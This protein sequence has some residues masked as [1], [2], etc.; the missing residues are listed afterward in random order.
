MYIY[1]QSSWPNFFWSSSKITS[2]LADVSHL[3]G[4]ML[5]LMEAMGFESR[6]EANL[7]ILTQ[8]VIKTSEIE[9]ERLDLEQ[10]RSSLAKRLGMDYERSFLPDRNVDG[11]VDV[12]FDATQHYNKKLTKERLFGWHAALFPMGRT[13]LQR[14]RVGTWRDESSG[15]MQVIS[16]PYGREKIHYEAPSYSVL[17]LEMK[18]F[19]KWFNSNS[20]ASLLLKSAVAHFW[21]VTIHPFDD[22]NGRIG[23][24]ISDMLLAQSEKSSQ[25]FYSMSS[26]ILR[27]RNDYYHV[28]ETCQK[29]T[30]DITLW[31]EWYLDCLKHAIESSDKILNKVIAKAK[32]WQKYSNQYFNDRQRLILNLLLDGFEGKLISSKWAKISKCSQDTALR[33]ITE[34]LHRGILV[35]DSAGGR[36]TAY[37]LK[38]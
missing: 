30:L 38:T 27:E 20:E 3:Q 34:L 12:L 32:F 37:E 10:V 6:E 1:Q 15:E 2:Q 19:L 22:G 31:M 17:Q 11:I 24:A 29:S 23:R 21:F 14:I 18:R 9:G 13:G 35:K 7:Q 4:R 8:D 36:S 25:R 26:Q 33:D 16:G 5:G 28:L